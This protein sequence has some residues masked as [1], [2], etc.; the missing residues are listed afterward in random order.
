MYEHAVL[1]MQKA[2]EPTDILWKNITGTRGLFVIRR[3]GLF[4][5]GLFLLFF[6]TTPT[7]LFVNL[8]SLDQ[9]HF[10]DFEWSKDL[11]MG[12]LIKDYITPMGV[13][14]VNVLLLVLIDAICLAAPRDPL[15]LLTRSV[16]Q[17]HNLLEFKHAF[18]SC[19]DHV[20]HLG[21]R[22]ESKDQS[23]QRSLASSLTS[24]KG[25]RCDISAGLNLLEQQRD[26][27]HVPCD[28]TSRYFF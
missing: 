12:N 6:V 19:S 23:R 4:L 8:K 28:P 3:F 2:T 25:I 22:P 21:E 17:I 15:T 26:L 11:P 9:T 27:L 5:L 18:H 14:A 10:L 13:L 1:I 24:G 7:V 16:P 20:Q